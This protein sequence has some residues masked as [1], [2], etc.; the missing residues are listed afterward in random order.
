MF[1]RHASWLKTKILKQ[2]KTSLKV[3]IHASIIRPLWPVNNLC[4]NSAFLCIL[5]LFWNILG[6]TVLCGDVSDYLYRRHKSIF[7]LLLKHAQPEEN[8]EVLPPSCAL[9]KKRVWFSFYSSKSSDLPR[10]LWPPILH[11][12]FLPG[13]GIRIPSFSKFCFFSNPFP[14]IRFSNI[15]GIYPYW[16][17]SCLFLC[18]LNIGL[19]SLETEIPESDTSCPIPLCIPSS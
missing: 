6:N 3:N 14:L 9:S 11:H 4:Y 19:W 16:K 12:G 10:V 15:L 17:G 1:S 8:T 7:L 18:W 13:K 5:T 2:E